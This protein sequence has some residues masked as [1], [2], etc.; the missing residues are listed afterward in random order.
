MEEVLAPEVPNLYASLLHR[1]S[2]FFHGLV[3]SPSQEVVVVALLAARDLRSNLGSNLDLVRRMTKL[4]PWTVGRGQL[5]SAL[6][7][8]VRKEVPDQDS[9]R[10]PYLQKLLTWRLQAH[11]TAD[12]GEFERLEGLINSLVSN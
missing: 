9:W 8:A 11:Y 6:D 4:D 12:Q 10:V 1:F 2:S 5:R 7:R 3:T